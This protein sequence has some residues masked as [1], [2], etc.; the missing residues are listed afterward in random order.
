MS[1]NFGNSIH[2]Y[3]RRPAREKKCQRPPKVSYL[4]MAIGFSHPRNV[5]ANLPRSV[6][7]PLNRHLSRLYLRQTFMSRSST[8]RI[9]LTTTTQ[10]VA[11]RRF[12]IV[13]AWQSCLHLPNIRKRARPRPRHP[14]YSLIEPFIRAAGYSA[15]GAG[16]STFS[17][18]SRVSGNQRWVPAFEGTNGR[19]WSRHDKLSFR[20]YLCPMLRIET[21][22]EDDGRWLAEVPALP[23][24]LS[25]GATDPKR[26][27]RPRRWRWA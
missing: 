25:Y 18:H 12:S 10:S 15:S 1:T 2:E 6:Y 17:A 26:G 9:R 3:P 27:P 16:R 14:K 21:E 7:R 13:S 20:C 11:A 19:A 5:K 22:C 23:G 4:A 24:V 8:S